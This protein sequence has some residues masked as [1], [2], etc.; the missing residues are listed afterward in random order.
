[1]KTNLQSSNTDLLNHVIT[2]V[3]DRQKCCIYYETLKYEQS[4]AP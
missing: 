1:M 4:V 3:T 2:Q